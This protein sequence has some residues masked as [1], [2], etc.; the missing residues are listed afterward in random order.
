VLLEPEDERL[1]DD[2]EQQPRPGFRRNA[3]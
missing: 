3:Q 1:G 2:L